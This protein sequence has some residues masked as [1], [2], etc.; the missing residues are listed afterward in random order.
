MED[1]SH[2][3]PK[4]SLQISCEKHMEGFV[5]SHFNII[6]LKKNHKF[7]SEN[8]VAIIYSLTVAP[9]GKIVLSTSNSGYS[10]PNQ[11]WL[12]QMDL[13]LD[14][15]DGFDPEDECF[16]LHEQGVQGR[17]EMKLFLETPKF[18]SHVQLLAPNDDSG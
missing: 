5:I 18:I 10:G 1:L 12:E 16:L 4:N 9:V 11:L 13:I 15:L 17:S 8:I 3:S 6:F 14:K 7:Y 2:H